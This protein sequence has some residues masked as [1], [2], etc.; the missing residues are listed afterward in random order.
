[1]SK[2]YVIAVVCKILVVLTTLL[3][4]ILVNRGLG[5][6]LKGDYA[7]IIN[8]VDILYAIFSLGLGQC[9]ATF[10]RKYGNSLRDTFML[11]ALTQGC[12]FLLVGLVLSN[13]FKIEFGT[14]IV[15]LTSISIVNVVVSMIAV[16]EESVK[17]NI[18]LTSINTLHLFL[19]IYIYISG[20][21]TLKSFLICYGFIELLR[22]II[23]MKIYELLP[24]KCNFSFSHISK[25]YATG[26]ITMIVMLLININYYLDIIMLKKLSDSYNVGLY[27]VGVTFSNMFLLIPDAFKEVLFGDSTK[28]TFSKQ[29]AYSSIKVAILISFI[30]LVFFFFVGKF[31]IKF[32]Y[33]NDYL[34]SYDLTMILFCGSFSMI[35]FKILQPVYIAFGKQTK[36]MVFLTCSAVAN[37][38]ANLIL[39]PKYNCTG[40]AISSAISYTI[41]GSLFLIDFV[42]FGI[43]E[44]K[45]G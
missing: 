44:R 24:N 40:A 20:F 37:I 25:I 43:G 18:V 45:D 16:I 42:R 41:C 34:P 30:I 19:L 10:K 11:L 38:I 6:Q 3:I 8:Y 33:G 4:S 5:V 2:R 21:C 26:F 22:I 14:E 29:T 28:K 35:F 15:I 13:L 9:Y 23:L 1:V 12:L 17:R 7:Y 27:S 32:L 36:A 31:A 39:I